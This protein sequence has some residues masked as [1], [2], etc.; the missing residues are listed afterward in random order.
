MKVAK[1]GALNEHLEDDCEDEDCRHVPCK[2]KC[3]EWAHLDETWT[4]GACNTCFEAGIEQA[5]AS[6]GC[7]VLFVKG[8]PRVKV[9]ETEVYCEDCWTDRF[10]ELGKRQVS[11]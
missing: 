11:A 7:E 9:T 6:Q 5:C 8:D 2:F 4:K 3:G 10:G 1:P